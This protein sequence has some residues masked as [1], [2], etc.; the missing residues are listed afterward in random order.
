MYFSFDI[1][2]NGS[3][4]WKLLKFVASGNQE[5]TKCFAFANRETVII[6]IKLI[7]DTQCNLFNCD[8][9]VDENGLILPRFQK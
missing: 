3:G 5:K 9:Y 4:E 8:G 1:A 6:M 7:S 2:E